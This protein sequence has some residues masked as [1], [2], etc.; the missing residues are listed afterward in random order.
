MTSS[1]LNSKKGRIMSQWLWSYWKSISSTEGGVEYKNNMKIKSTY[2]AFRLGQNTSNGGWVCT[3]CIMIC[4]FTGIVASAQTADVNKGC[5]PL[6]VRFS[7]PELSGY[8]WRFDDGGTAAV[9]NPDHVFTTPGVYNVELFDGPNGAIIGR[10][11]ITVYPDP[12]IAITPSVEEGCSPLEVSFTSSITIDP[13]ITIQSVRWSF[14]DG[15]SSMAENPTYVYNR[16]GLYDVSLEIVTSV[17]DCNKTTIFF[18][19]IQVDGVP[20]EFEAINEYACRAPL[21]VYFRNN[22]EDQPGVSYL[23]DFGNG[24]TSTEIQP[25]T[26]TYTEEGVFLITLTVTTEKGCVS[27]DSFELNI[28]PI[29]VDIN[30]P[31]VVCLG[32]EFKFNNKTIASNFRW[33]LGEDATPE[34]SSQFNPEIEYSSPGIKTIRLR[35]WEVASCITD[36]TFQI[37]VEQIDPSFT[38]EPDAGC[39]NPSDI[40]VSATR[41]DYALYEWTLNFDEIDAEGPETNL[42]YTAIE[43]DSFYR[44]G[45]DTVLVGL[46]AISVHGCSAQIYEE[47]YYIHPNAFLVPDVTSGCAPLT[48]TF[49]DST[50]S[51]HP[52]IKY[53]FYYGTGEMATFDDSGA[54]TYT[55]TEPGEYYVKL[56]IQNQ[57]G[58]IDSSDGIW[59]L[60]GEEITTE[61]IEMDKT[62]VCIG[63]SITFTFPDIDDR[64][65]TWVCLTDDGRCSFDWTKPTGTHIFNTTPGTFDLNTSIGYNGCYS[66]VPSPGSITVR[67]AKAIGGYHID[68]PTPYDLNLYSRSLGA[69]RLEWRVGD[70]VIGTSDTLVHTFP[71]TGDYWIYLE[72]EDEGSDC[73][74]D[75]DSFLV[76][77]RD[78]QASFTFPEKVCNNIIELLDASA[79]VDVDPTCSKGYL[80]NI[81]GFRP[82]MID[83]DSLY[84]NIPPGNN[85]PIRLIVEDINGCQDTTIRQV[86]SYAIRPELELPGTHICFPSSATFSE[87]GDADTTVLFWDWD[88]GVSGQ[89]VTHA[90]SA[91]RDVDTLFFSL[92]MTD[93]IG[94]IEM[95]D[96][97][98]VVYDPFTEIQTSPGTGVCIG[99]TIAFFAEDYTEQ[100][101]FLNYDWDFFGFGTSDEER[102]TVTFPTSGDFWIYLTYTEDASGCSRRDSVEIQ[103]VDFPEADF[104]TSADGVDPL[105]H[106]A[107]IEMQD[108]STTDGPVEYIWTTTNGLNSPLQNPTHSFGKGTFDITLMVR[109]IYGCSDMTTQ[110]VTLVGPEGDFTIDEDEVCLDKPI[111][112]TLIDTSEVNSFSWFLGD[113]TRIDDVSPLSYQY[114]ELPDDSIRMIDLVLRTVENDCELTVS[115]PITYIEVMAA[116]T[117]MG[118]DYCE[119]LAA[120]TN[121]SVGA[122]AFSWDFGGGA[123]S[124]EEEPQHFFGGFGSFPVTLTATNTEKDCSHTITQDVFLESVESIYDM[125]N[126][127]SPNDDGLNDYFNV[128]IRDPYEEFV[129]VKA[130]KIYNRWG[131]LI[132][133][134]NNPDMGWNG[135]VRDEN[136]PAE[137]YAYYIE[138]ELI[139]CTTVQR[140]GSVTLIR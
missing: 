88:F 46:R 57:G 22:T 67:G 135:R 25:D 6:E 61:P 18:E 90:F 86:S 84:V 15:G 26:F 36:T 8:F 128:V 98:L 24:D 116:F 78:I 121:L 139:D 112:L 54:H 52:V 132:Y 43:R 28:G 138:F 16:P 81:P 115:V 5:V 17:A 13:E 38:F 131:H 70:E 129:E 42:Q 68:C 123:T 111:T 65:D 80:W 125:P 2:P 14:G 37:E 30:I 31:D 49:R 79:S 20:A 32:Q 93:A 19:R 101:S 66:D 117:A 7:A 120:F 75:I 63:E 71:V 122:D 83:Y 118:L 97:F 95:R 62:E 12:I 85:Q 137:V 56:F 134:N 33:Q 58:C 102:A 114:D 110:S 69:T 103:V 1:D 82:R 4:M 64:I 48:V 76:H 35:T 44:H 11:E 124:E 10:I 119:G 23:W 40:L 136:A 92:T 34:Q 100:G 96:S 50:E 53:E 140:Q 89:T 94:C 73:P 39:Q 107:I 91:A 87:V 51:I 127:F 108:R 106:P 72:A 41:Q 77:I 113:G 55:Y 130:F 45:I 27:I 9:R 99:D 74:P 29:V 104:I 109:S 126:V 105:C 47:F 60:V 21:D 133:D 59:I 3:L